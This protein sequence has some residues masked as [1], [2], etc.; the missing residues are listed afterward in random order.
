VKSARGAVLAVAVA[1]VSPAPGASASGYDAYLAWENWARPIPG[2]RAG[3]ASSWDRTGGHF[4]A[5]HY[6]VPQGLIMGSI[7]T[8]AATLA[9]PGIIYRFWMPHRAAATPFA[10]RMY[11]DG[12]TVP[13]IQTDSGELL[14]GDFGYF[15]A[16][17]VMTAAGGQVCY[18]PIPFEESVRIETENIA[19]E[20]HWYQYSFRTFAPGTSIDSWTGTLDAETQAA[21]LATAA[22]FTG[23]GQHPAGPS[24]TAIRNVVGPLV[25]PAGAGFGA[26]DLA[27]PGIVRTIAL[28]MDGAGDEELDGL[29]LEVTWDDEERPAIDAPVSWFFGAG[30]ERAPYRSV[31]MGTDGPDGFYCYWPMPFHGRCRVE[32]VNT[33][34]LPIGV[35]SVVIEHE[36]GPVDEGLAYLHA[37]ANRTVIVPGHD[38]HVLLTATGSGHYVGNLLYIQQDHGNHVFLEG[39]D[40]IVVDGTTTLNGTGLEDA[41]NGG[42]YYNWVNNPMDEPEG[43]SPPFAIRPLSGILRV[44]RTAVPDFARADQY[45]W[46]IGDRVPFAS[47]IDVRVETQGYAWAPGEYVSVAFWYL[48]P[49]PA[50]GVETIGAAGALGLELLPAAPNP[51]RESASIR[52]V[53]PAD[54]IVA[55]DVLDVTGRRVDSLAEGPLGAGPH[56]VRW[57]PGTRPSGVYFVRLRAGSWTET[58]KLVLVR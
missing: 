19:E 18:E 4:D 3:L 32:L 7:D 51:V 52:F 28:R 45:R 20:W 29:R 27:G 35:D 21:R 53:L 58:R 47:S 54:M 12:E 11:F 8:I 50:T 30:H 6:E 38:G 42:F 56:E 14:K 1:L 13:R 22:M 15:D 40:I 2:E 33:T 41:Y 34:A 24:A 43:P 48:L 49:P 55:L 31:P 26:V 16:P 25:V 23:S 17:L 36:P 44:E 57:A 9:G 46:M 10:L 37:T 5:N 39:D